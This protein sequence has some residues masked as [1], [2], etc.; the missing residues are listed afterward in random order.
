MREVDVAVTGN[1][2]IDVDYAEVSGARERGVDGKIEAL[3]IAVR[4][5]VAEGEKRT[6]FKLLGLQG[7]LDIY[8]EP[9]TRVPLMICGKVEIA[10]SV[11]LRLR[12]AVL[13]R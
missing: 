3:R 1:E 7:D 10:G 5:R 2:W 12:R 4:P 11:R 9:R 8:V 6:D 13:K